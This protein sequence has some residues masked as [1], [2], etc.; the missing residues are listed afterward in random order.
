MRP[1]R[2]TS[3]PASRSG[4]AGARE[5]CPSRGR[6]GPP[7]GSRRWSGRGGR[8]RG[9]VHAPVAEQVVLDVVLGVEDD[10]RHP[11]PVGGRCPCASARPAPE[12]RPAGSGGSRGA[13]SGS[14]GP[15]AGRWSP[16]R[17]PRRCGAA[18]RSRP[19]P[20]R[21]AAAQVVAAADLSEHVAEPGRERVGVHRDRDLDPTA[22][23]PSAARASSSSSRDCRPRRTSAAP[24]SVGSHGVPRRTTTRPTSRSSARIRWLTAL[25]VTWSARAAASKVPWSAIATSAST[26][27]RVVGHE[28]M[29]MNHDRTCAGLHTAAQP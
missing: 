6:A 7:R 16:R 10:D 11:L 14:P 1:P 19:G 17:A 23:R 5:A 8:R 3:R 27:C 13:P 15:A 20:R 25:G 21:R 24:A 4:T 2:V 9:S 26:A 29:L 12:S 22:S 18:R 28:A